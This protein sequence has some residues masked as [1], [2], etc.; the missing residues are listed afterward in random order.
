MSSSILWWGHKNIF[1]GNIFTVEV[2]DCE[3]EINLN[4]EFN[5][6]L[7]NNLFFMLKNSKMTSIL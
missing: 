7:Y 1:A 5:S 6:L 2:C 4:A 3:N